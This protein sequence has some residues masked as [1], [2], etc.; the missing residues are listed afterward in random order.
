MLCSNMSNRIVA[1]RARCLLIDFDNAALTEPITPTSATDDEPQT[2]DANVI[3]K[4][5]AERTVSKSGTSRANSLLSNIQQGTARYIA[6]AVAKGQA[7]PPTHPS[8]LKFSPMP[9]LTGAALEAYTNAYGE[10]HYKT[11]SD[12]DGMVHGAVPPSRRNPTPPTA[13]FSHKPAHDVESIFWTLAVTLIL[14]LPEGSCEPE[15]F[16]NSAMSAR[17]CL[18]DHRIGETLE[19]WRS[20][21]MR[22][23]CDDFEL[24]LHPGLRECGL[25]E[26]LAELAKQV[27][28]EYMFLEP[29]PRLDHLHEAFRRILLNYL[30]DVQPDVQ[31]N[32]GVS[33]IIPTKQEEDTKRKI[34]QMGWEPPAKRSRT[35]G[36]TR[37]VSTSTRTMSNFKE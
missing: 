5:L 34:Q 14:A 32:P 31:L 29:Q 20:P 7:L 25:G 26:L 9:T 12:P 27:R 1:D 8:I 16:T 22:W 13:A 11:Y 15:V 36:S 24:A 4:E 21:I 2:A 37:I 3:G 10:D 6:R 18:I 28:P 23:D 19:D 33:R 17:E 35:E 30:V